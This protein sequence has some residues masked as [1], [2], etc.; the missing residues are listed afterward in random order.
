MTRSRTTLV[1][2]VLGSASAGWDS[3]SVL[4]GDDARQTP[5]PPASL[6]ELDLLRSVLGETSPQ[7]G[8]VR[9]LV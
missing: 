3:T 7:P 8:G 1:L 4:R 9:Y 5:T 2:L 6:I